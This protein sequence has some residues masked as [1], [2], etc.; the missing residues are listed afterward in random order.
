MGAFN[1]IL[2]ANAFNTNTSVY[3][4]IYNGQLNTIGQKDDK[5]EVQHTYFYTDI[6][7]MTQFGGSSVW[8]YDFG[9]TVSET[10]LV[11]KP[12]I[13]SLQGNYPNPFNPETTITFI[14]GNAFMRSIGTDKSVPY[15]VSIDIYNTKGQ[16]VRSLVNGSFSQGEHKVVWNGTDDRGVSVG[17]GVYFYRMKTENYTETKKMLL[18][19]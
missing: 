19:K 1:K 15:S 2:T 16:K 5:K 11:E 7:K 10:D 17:S 4:S 14:V 12:Y 3:Y 8:V 9:Y 13:V 18:M 6:N